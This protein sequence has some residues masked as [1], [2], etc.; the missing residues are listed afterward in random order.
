MA[1]IFGR[2]QPAVN[3][4][5]LQYFRTT[6]PALHARHDAIFYSR[7]LHIGFLHPFFIF[8]HDRTEPPLQGARRYTGQCAFCRIVY[9]IS[10]Y[11]QICGNIF[12]VCILVFCIHF[13]FLSMIVL[14]H[15][16]K[17]L[18]GILGNACFCRIV[19]YISFYDQICGNIFLVC[20][21]VFASI[22]HF[23]P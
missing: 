13:S 23:Y 5:F 15:P 22:F 12:L 14:S 2:L 10:F 1:Q 4:F 7:G 17:V 21:L 3:G 11:D 20:I 18:G 6:M 19:Y 16:C 9:Y 8:I